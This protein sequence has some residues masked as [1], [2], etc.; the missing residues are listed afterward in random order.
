[1]DNPEEPDE[2]RRLLDLEGANAAF[3][4][5][6]SDTSTTEFK[7]ALW[8]LRSGDETATTVL[9]MG[10]LGLLGSAAARLVSLALAQVDRST[11]GPL[12][13]RLL[14]LVDGAD[15]LAAD[16]LPGLV[17]AMTA[18]QEWKANV[19]PRLRGLSHVHLPANLRTIPGIDP[20]QVLDFE[21]SE[22]IS[23]YRA[24]RP[25][26]AEALLRAPDHASMRK[27]LTRRFEAILTDC[28][29]LLTES[30]SAAT[31]EAV[32]FADEGI[33]ALSAG[34]VGAAQALFAVTLDS[35]VWS[36]PE[37]DRIAVSKHH[38]GSEPERLEDRQLQFALAFMPIW[39]A[40]QTFFPNAN[41]PVPRGF[42]RH[43]SLHRVS[44]QQYSKRNALQ[45]LMLLSGAIG[46]VAVSATQ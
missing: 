14:G 44:R 42:S 19:E 13:T 15:E 7:K 45:A 11:A 38:R 16:A 28:E 35:L 18:A 25:S 34:H 36:L 30:R 4:I 22:G 29:S 40:H 41:D 31:S 17:H 23:L 10:T 3:A 46:Y 24:P 8:Q 43:A 33:A 21:R 26:I 1:V 12:K 27:V 2:L 39:T 32:D 9:I 5:A 6:S 20:S 37:P